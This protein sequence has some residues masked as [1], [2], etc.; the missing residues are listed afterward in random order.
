MG[1]A[2]TFRDQDLD[3]PAYQV[4]SR[5]PKKVLRTFVDRHEQAVAVYCHRGVRHQREERR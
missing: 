4:S 5:V 1:M 3:R 2:E